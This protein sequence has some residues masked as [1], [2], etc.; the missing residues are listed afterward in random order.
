MVIRLRGHRRLL[1]SYGFVTMALIT[2]VVAQRG[3]RWGYDSQRLHRGN[4]PTWEIDQ[5]FK[6]DVFTFVRIKYDSAYGYGRQR[7]NWQIDYPD[8]DLNFSLRLQQLTSLNVNPDPIVLELTDERLFDYPFIYIIEPGSL[9]FSEAEVIALRRYC[10]N[11]G[12]LMVNDFWGTLNTK[13]CAS[14]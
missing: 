11:G 2:G 8:S 3:R 9:M 1:L 7:G 13:T 10:L 5:E 14:S 4:V 6:E 12:F